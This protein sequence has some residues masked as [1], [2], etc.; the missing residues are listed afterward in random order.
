MPLEPFRRNW[1]F[2]SPQ[3]VAEA[4]TLSAYA[5]MND[6][7][8]YHGASPL[9]GLPKAHVGRVTFH[10]KQFVRHGVRASWRPRV[11]LRERALTISYS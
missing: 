5:C 7:R 1:S 3:V 2:K 4:S 9:S 11:I 8:T 10:V 6:M